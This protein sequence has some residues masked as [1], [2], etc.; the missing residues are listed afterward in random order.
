MNSTGLLALAS[1]L[2]GPTQE[3]PAKP[4]VQAQL[5]SDVQSIQP[6][7]PFFVGLHLVME[8]G[9]HTYWMNPGDSGLPTRVAWKPPEGVS[10]GPFEWPAPRAFATGPLVSYGYA[11]EVL[12]LARVTTPDTLQ[13]GQSLSLGG[14]ASWLECKEIC[15]PGKAEIS[16]SLPVEAR[17]P[18][19]SAEAGRFAQARDRL[20]R[21]AKGWRLTAA[22]GKGQLLLTV[23]PPAGFGP[24]PVGASFF[25][26]QTGLV[27]HAGPQKL[28]RV[29]GGARLEI[30]LAANAV[31]PLDRL[32]G[33]LLI[34]TK[35]KEI[36][37]KVEVPLAGASP[38]ST[39]TKGDRP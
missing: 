7:Q 19:P 1:L 21:D 3:P 37:L 29:P 38:S 27:E 30:P 18:Q 31:R 28:V 22:L 10:V 25:A 33:V 4:H 34:P 6:G 16:L 14:R 15:I 26:E 24:I 39:I 17:T 9:W 5:L 8:P 12:L 36:A 32:R 20:P 13:P 2:I 11:G 35:A 23:R